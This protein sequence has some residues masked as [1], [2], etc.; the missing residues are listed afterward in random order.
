MAVKFYDV[1]ADGE[2]AEFYVNERDPVMQPNG[3][4]RYSASWACLSSY[5]AF[6]HYWHSMGRPFNKFAPEVEEDYLLSKIGKRVASCDV[7]VESVRREIKSLRRGGDVSKEEARNA[8][9][10]VNEILD[11]DGHFGSPDVF[12]KNLSEDDD[13]DKLGIEWS[14]LSSME[15]EG[16]ALQFVRKLW[17]AF[18]EALKK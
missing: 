1:R 11:D 17:P 8:W 9:I 2:W 10:A 15:W 12:M 13:L 18:V 14:E 16:D 6:G 7:I 3:H 4:L 5:G